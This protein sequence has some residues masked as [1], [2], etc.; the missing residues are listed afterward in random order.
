MALK[1]TN[2]RKAPGPD[3]IN[4]ELLK[5]GGL[6]LITR[7]HILFNTCWITR[8]ISHTWRSACVF[9]S[10]GKEIRLTVTIIGALVSLIAVIKHMPKYRR[11][12]QTSNGCSN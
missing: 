12:A 2:N 10:S 5:Y 11:K 9:R 8:S 6:T 1:S 7:L 3:G 4:L